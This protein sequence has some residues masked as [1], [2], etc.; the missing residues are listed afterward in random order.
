LK[1]SVPSV[2]EQNAISEFLN[3]AESEINTLRRKF[4]ALMKQK[5]GLM[6][7]LLTGKVRVKVDVEAVKA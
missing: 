4:T 1:F 2:P 7:Q 5:K 6:Q 3:A